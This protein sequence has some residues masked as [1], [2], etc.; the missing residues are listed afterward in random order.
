MKNNLLSNKTNYLSI[1]F[2][3]INWIVYFFLFLL[4]LIG[5][6]ILYSVSQGNFT[7]LVS[8]HLIKFIISSIALFT[9]CFVKINL[10]HRYSYLIYIISITLLILVL[11][12]GVN[13]QGSNRWISL[14]GFTFQPSELTK[15]ALVICL[16]R[17]YDD[18]ELINNNN[19]IKIFFPILLIIFPISFVLNQPDL[20]TAL[21]ILIS[22]LSVI[23]LSGIGIWYIIFSA[24]LVGSFAPVIWNFL[25]DYQKQRIITFINPE[26]DP[27]GSGYHIAQSKIAIGS[28]GFLGKGYMK[29]SQSHLEFIPEMHTDFVFSIF[30]EEFGFLGSIILIFIYSYVIFYGFLC[31]YK[32]KTTFNRLAIAGLTLNIFLYFII[33]ISMVIGIIPV[34]GVPLPLVS[35]GG[36]S[37]LITMISF[38]LIMNLNN[39]IKN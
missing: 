31:A 28:G 38:G 4:A 23:F 20:G 13:D 36:S 9:A 17:Y 2:T 12:L 5:S 18:Y 7:P 25:Y 22:S 3:R 21:L 15:I 33:N 34:V 30:S 8:S 10:I 35:Y 39:Y 27:L 14:F 19:F 32:A 24:I 6:T 37:M 1:F 26:Q 29:G 11:F 16:S